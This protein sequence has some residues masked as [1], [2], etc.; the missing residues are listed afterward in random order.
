V[1]LQLSETYSVVR[2][3]LEALS[4]PALRVPVASEDVPHD[5]QEDDEENDPFDDDALLFVA[6]DVSVIGSCARPRARFPLG[7]VLPRLAPTYPTVPPRDYPAPIPP[8]AGW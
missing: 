6:N 2:Q 8:P 1:L 7:D 4:Q 5:E 3:R